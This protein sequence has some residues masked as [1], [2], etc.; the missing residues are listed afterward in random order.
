MNVYRIDCRESE[1]KCCRWQN[2]INFDQKTISKCY[3]KR[4]LPIKT[5]IKWIRIRHIKYGKVDFR[6][7]SSLSL[8]SI[9]IDTQ[10]LCKFTIG[11]FT[12]RSNGTS[13]DDDADAS[14]IATIPSNIHRIDMRLQWIVIDSIR[15]NACV[16]INIDTLTSWENIRPNSILESHCHLLIPS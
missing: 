6:F 1:W 11:S 7:L 12:L 15:N 10:M 8:D 9:G 2:Q 5:S 13:F 16:H 3:F 4:M 14:A